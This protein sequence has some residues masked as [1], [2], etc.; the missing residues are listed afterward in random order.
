MGTPLVVDSFGGAA[1]SHSPHSLAYFL[2]HAHT[3]HLVGLTAE[4]S[5]GVIHCSRITAAL[6]AQRFGPR[7]SLASRLRT[8]DIDQSAPTEDHDRDRR[9]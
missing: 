5:R 6:V 9:R 4:W 3:D 8:L 7:S 2:T 1:A